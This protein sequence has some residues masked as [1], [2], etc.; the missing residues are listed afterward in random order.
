MILRLVMSLALA[1]GLS[2]PARAEV[3]LTISYS[4]AADLY[5]TMDN[6]ALW[7]NGFN[8]PRYRS[9]W[10]A[11]FGWSEEDQA[12][13]LRYREYRRRTFVDSSQDLDVTTSPHGLFASS[14]SNAQ[15]ADPLADYL[16]AQ[17]DIKTALRNLPTIASRDDARMLRGFFRHFEPKW[18]TLLGESAPLNGYASK[19]RA[20]IDDAFFSSY[21]DQ[22]AQ[23][24]G[25]EAEGEFRVFFTQFPAGEGTS[26]N[27]MSGNVLVLNT[28]LDVAF[29][30]GDWDT[31]VAHE[32]A[33]YL[34]SQQSDAQKRELSDRFLAIC[35]LPGRANR[36][37]LIEEPLA[38]AVGQAAYSQ[39]VLG[40][41]LDTRSNWYSVPWID[42]T[43]RTLAPSVIDA[44]RSGKTLEQ[45]TIVEEA[46]ERCRDLISVTESLD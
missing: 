44:I 5:Q 3:R 13:A 14:I 27:I 20:R 26:A 24:Y 28:P 37:W 46:A 45:S 33:H 42:I 11:R 21:V 35:S 16:V 4:E 32:F 29:E 8:D 18:R 17:P 23:F 6:V 9:A 43:A 12:W 2:V 19:L 39:L 7:W 15:G 1:I 34:S 40:Q 10:E 25:A 31:I 22:I 30:S 36:G 41:P 38:V